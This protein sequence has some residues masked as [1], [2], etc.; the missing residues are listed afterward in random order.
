M[1][2]QMAFEEVMLP[3]WKVYDGNGISDYPA[4]NFVFKNKKHGCMIVH[5]DGLMV[6]NKPLHLLVGDDDVK[7][8]KVFIENPANFYDLKNEVSETVIAE[9]IIV[10]TKFK[11]REETFVNN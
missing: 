8:L 5:P 2:Y 10:F 6:Y 7:H 9:A 3:K 4:R 11:E 1:G